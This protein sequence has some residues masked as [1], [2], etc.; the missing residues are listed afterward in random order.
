MGKGNDPNCAAAVPMAGPADIAAPD[1]PV[2]RSAGGKILRDGDQLKI[3]F[4]DFEIRA[5]GAVEHPTDHTT[6]TVDEDLNTTHLA[7]LVVLHLQEG[8]LT[9]PDGCTV[10]PCGV[11]AMTSKQFERVADLGHTGEVTLT[12]EPQPAPPLPDLPRATWKQLTGDQQQALLSLYHASDDGDAFILN[13]HAEHRDFYDWTQDQRDEHA[14]R[15]DRGLAGLEDLGLASSWSEGSWSCTATG[16]QTLAT[17]ERWPQL[18]TEPARALGL[19]AEHGTVTP[20]QLADRC[21]DR[22]DDHR[23]G[24]RLHQAELILHQLQGWGL[25]HRDQD[26]FTA[27]S[28]GHALI[29]TRP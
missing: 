27:T 10:L 4:A 15:I 14:A 25:L 22:L 20:Q 21:G 26:S 19:V 16:D 29:A 1:L 18:Q 11:Y 12:P 23:P 7:P 13:I 17:P 28:D 8:T 2:W 24:G 5:R 9:G 6:V 3:S